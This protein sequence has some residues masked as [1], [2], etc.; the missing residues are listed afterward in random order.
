MEEKKIS[1]EVAVHKAGLPLKTNESLSEFT[2]ALRDAGG[3]FFTQKLNLVNTEK[4]YASC[5][6]VETFATA[7]V[8]EIYKSGEGVKPMERMR[9]YAVKYS[10]DD[11]GKF[12]FDSMTEVQRVTRFEAKTQVAKSAD[13]PEGWELAEKSLWSGV[14]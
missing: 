5:Y 6:M 2:Q 11:A 14:V 8:F 12:A 7:A 9:F 1:Y 13:I 10:R 3:Q 4:S